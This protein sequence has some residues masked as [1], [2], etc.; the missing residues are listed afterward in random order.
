MSNVPCP[1]CGNPVTVVFNGGGVA[2]DI[3]E[4]TISW[5][6]FIG[7]AAS[8]AY[9]TDWVHEWHSFNGESRQLGIFEEQV[10]EALHRDD[11]IDFDGGFEGRL[12][13]NP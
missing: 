1:E 6:G 5:G 2:V 10:I 13:A 8:H 3:A 4:G 11:V 9:C 12:R 7:G